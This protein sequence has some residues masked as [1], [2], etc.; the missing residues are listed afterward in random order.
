M[1]NSVKKARLCGLMTALILSATYL[2]S[3]GN[4][5]N[6]IKVDVSLTTAY[7][8]EVSWEGS[9]GERYVIYHHRAEELRRSSDIERV[10]LFFTSVHQHFCTVLLFFTSALFYRAKDKI[11]H[12]AVMIT[13]VNAMEMPTIHFTRSVF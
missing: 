2:T 6:E 4:E 10:F 1:K 12:M 7:L 9:G 8:A 13:V 11:A 5:K 3:C